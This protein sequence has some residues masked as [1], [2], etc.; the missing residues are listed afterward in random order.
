MALHLGLDWDV[1]T[2]RWVLIAIFKHL[3]TY[4]T[5][6][7]EFDFYMLCASCPIVSDS[8]SQVPGMGCVFK[9]KKETKE[10]VKLK[11]HDLLCGR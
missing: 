1:V 6:F 8:R 3:F 4:G 11:K 2:L 7:M 10:I 5:S 9:G